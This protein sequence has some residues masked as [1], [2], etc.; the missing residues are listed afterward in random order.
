MWQ[1]TDAHAWTGESRPRLE[2]ARRTAAARRTAGGVLLALLLLLCL[3][4]GLRPRHFTLNGQVYALR[5][6]G[7]AADCA[8]LL[9][10]ATD[11]GNLLD[12]RG[13]VL[14]SGRGFPPL[15]L[16][17]NQPVGPQALIHGGDLLTV[18]PPRDETEPLTTSLERLP[19]RPR[20]LTGAAVSVPDGALPFV[21]LRRAEYGRYSGKLASVEVAEVSPVV[22]TGAGDKKLIALTFDDGP[23]PYYTP[24]ILQILAKNGVKATFFLIG[25]V[26][27]SYPAVVRQEVAAG[28][29]IGVHTWTHPQLTH[30]SQAQV[31]ADSERCQR[32]LHSIA[33][34]ISI[35]WERPPYGATNATVKAG[36]QAAGLRQILWD[37]DPEDWRKP[38]AETIYQR[39]MHQVRTGAVV[40]SHDGGGDRTQTVA[41]YSR[42]VPDLISRGFHPVTLSQ[43]KGLSS[44]FSGQVIYNIDGQSFQV[45]PTAPALSLE[46]DA[47][48]VGL[49]GPILK[50]AGQLM[51]PAVPTFQRLGATCVYEDATQSLLVSSASGEYRLRLDSLRLTANDQ[52]LDLLQPPVL[53]SDHA[54]VPLALLLRIT[55]ATATL[56]EPNHVLRLFSAGASPATPQ[57]QAVLPSLLAWLADRPVVQG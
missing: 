46:I 3:A 43:L 45:Q 52:E 9:G 7:T 37:V 40:L 50:C 53:Y 30:L 8:R 14:V 23:S 13:A 41:A 1:V 22:S 10:Y 56:D 5:Q 6:A 51:V 26:A 19:P 29:E 4:A 27:E 57:G 12:A 25:E 54:Y 2:L 31:T 38:G 11:P 33:G 39:V 36:I 42:L 44:L 34:P 18:C 32:L 55:G 20:L 47:A 24:E 16:R 21:G 35:G 49:P 15:Y 48:P 28:M 17:N